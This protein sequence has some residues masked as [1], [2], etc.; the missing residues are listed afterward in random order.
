M[1]D[2]VPQRKILPVR[3]KIS[4]VLDVGDRDANTKMQSKLSHVEEV[5]QIFGCIDMGSK[6]YTLEPSITGNL[7]WGEITKTGQFKLYSYCLGTRSFNLPESV[8]LSKEERRKYNSKLRAK[9]E[10]DE[11]DDEESSE[12]STWGP[13]ENLD[14]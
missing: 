11:S 14:T 5:S 2:P 1:D 10:S 3:H 6:S 7:H 13:I 9:D 8:K 4:Q 12:S